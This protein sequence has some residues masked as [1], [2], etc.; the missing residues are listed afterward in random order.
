M[1]VLG[2]GEVVV[3]VVVGRN[4]PLSESKQTHAN[5]QPCC[6]FFTNS[7]TLETSW[8]SGGMKKTRLNT[9]I[10]ERHLKKRV[11]SQNICLNAVWVLK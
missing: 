8:K 1:C 10:S 11:V 4:V 7:P 2:G 6:F 5:T 9:S 3:Q